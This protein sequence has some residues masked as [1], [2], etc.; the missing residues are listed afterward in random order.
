ML[1][2]IIALKRMFN[3]NFF[4]FSPQKLVNAVTKGAIHCGCSFVLCLSFLSFSPFTLASSDEGFYESIVTLEILLE[5]VGN[6]AL[7]THFKDQGGSFTHYYSPSLKRSFVVDDELARVCKT[8]KGSK[9]LSC[10]P[11]GENEVSKECP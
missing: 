1:V 10:F 8:Y 11:C 7:V 6:T 5:V 3:V 2:R 4:K 9:I